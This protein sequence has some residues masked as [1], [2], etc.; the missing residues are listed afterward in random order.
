M[1]SFKGMSIGD[2]SKMPEFKQ[3]A[4]YF[5]GG[6]GPDVRNYKALQGEAM[7]EAG[8]DEQSI[9]Y[10]LERLLE[11]STEYKQYVYPVYSEEE[12]KE[13]RNK[14]DAAIIHFPAKRKQEI[15]DKNRPY[16]IL[17]AG[18]GFKNVCT[19]LESFPVAARLNEMG[20]DAFAFNYRVGGIAVLPKPLDDL[21][22]A[23]RFIMEHEKE[24]GVNAKN[25]IVCGFSA[26]GTITG[27]WGTANHGYGSYGLPKPK[28][29][30]PVYPGV[31][32]NLYM[33]SSLFDADSEKLYRKKQKEFLK[34]MYGGSRDPGLIASY[35]IDENIDKSCPPCYLCCCKDDQIVSWKN[36]L[37]LYE[38]LVSLNIPAR[39]EAGEF[40]GHGYGLGDHVSVK[41]WIG[42]A[43]SFVENLN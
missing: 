13:K 14:K 41:G 7:K 40:G 27:L 5:I 10:G 3:A 35:N 31:N 25:Y 17:A 43:I 36:S 6:Q 15:K 20:Y 30:F 9:C 22:R 18:G 32:A 28:A 19:V 34:K 11:I 26:G 38:K 33:D 23:V 37:A 16:V 21:A 39:L 24:F 2:L 4:P 1:R 8:W 29:L 12:R 42:R